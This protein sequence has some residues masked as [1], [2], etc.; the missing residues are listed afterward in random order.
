MSKINNLT[1]KKFNR[2]LV[3]K[4]SHSNKNGRAM[5]SCICDCGNSVI[6]CGHELLELKTQSCGC[7]NRESTSKRFKT[8]GYANGAD[9]KKKPLY[10]I[11]HAML[12]RCRNINNKSY[13]NYGGRGIFP[14]KSWIKFENFRNDMETSYEEHLKIY[15]R[16]NTCLERINN[17]K[18]YSKSNCKWATQRE[19]ANNRRGNRLI[20]FKG[21]TKTL[22]MWAEKIN[23]S[24]KTL[25]YRIVIYKW[26]IEIALTTPLWGRRKLA[27]I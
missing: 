7:W 21:E 13:K 2:L 12:E 27:K 11:W 25:W 1:G 16:R 22:S 4:Y 17:N 26:P 24:P 19:Q 3:I 14:D 5:W 6:V 8:H 20:L 10:M 15:G 23:L 18:G 9:G